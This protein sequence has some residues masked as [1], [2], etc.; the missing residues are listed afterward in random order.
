MAGPPLSAARAEETARLTLNFTGVSKPGGVIMAGVFDSRDAFDQD[1]ATA[2]VREL[3]D[4][5]SYREERYAATALTRHRSYRVHQ[6]PAML[7]LYRFDLAAS[8]RS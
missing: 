1:R 4:E 2:A 6:D 3:W 7:A 8:A 5:A